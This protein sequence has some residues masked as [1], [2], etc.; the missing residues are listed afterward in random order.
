MS[1]YLSFSDSAK[2]AQAANN[3]LNKGILAINH[4]FFNPVVLA[5][6]TGGGF[7]SNF[8]PLISIILNLVF[9]I[10]PASDTSV[11]LTGFFVLLISAVIVF[12]ITK[13]I[14]H[15]K[16]AIIACLLLLTNLFFFEY[17]LNFSTEIIFT[18]EILLSVYLFIIVKS[19][20]KY[21]GFIPLILMYFTR[22]QAIIIYLAFSLY[23]LLILAK[24]KQSKRKQFNYL[25]PRLI[26]IAVIFFLLRALGF[27]SV[28]T[29]HLGSINILPSLNPGTFIRGGGYSSTSLFQTASK[30]FYNTYNFL[31]DPSRLAPAGIFIFFILGFF[32]R[33]LPAKIKKFNLFTLITLS[34]FILSSAL[35][36]PNARY[37]HPAMPL[38]FISASI[39]LVQ[40]IKKA[41]LKFSNLALSVVVFFIL[42]PSIGHFTIDA[43]FRAQKYNTNKPPVYREISRIMA[44]HI[45]KDH[46]IITNLDAWAAWYEGLTTMWFPIKP[47]MLE[48]FQNKVDY[49]VIT[50]YKEHD[51]D[52]ALGEWSEVVYS[53]KNI[54]NEFLSENYQV[55][56][57]FEINP[58]QIYENREFIGTIL[59]S[60]DQ[61]N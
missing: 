11:A 34:L 9:R 56:T 36:L 20:Y 58:G 13:K 57:T 44:Q 51:A 38:V 15:L 53:P 29:S 39:S 24:T 17:S 22:P 28:F 59:V 33:N 32:L 16:S 6:Y 25:A 37:I 50:N 47:D 60:N 54:E 27:L 43:R 41:N 18:L 14:S 52:F 21:L 4:S 7:S 42:L 55:L 61:Q 45:P 26:G 19:R 40:I 5:E 8:R 3:L 30:L 12:K 23:L 2:Y 1:F 48:G 49:I 35:T 10:F 46:L 31:K